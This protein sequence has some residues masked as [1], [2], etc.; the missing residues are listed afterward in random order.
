M[1]LEKIK[2]EKGQVKKLRKKILKR[3]I[4]KLGQINSL[5]KKKIVTGKRLS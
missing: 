1:V 5:V 4:K 3:K 2:I